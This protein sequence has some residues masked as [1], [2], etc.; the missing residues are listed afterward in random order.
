MAG[1][2]LCTTGGTSKEIQALKN[3]LRKIVRER[4]F[5]NILGQT[6]L[7]ISLNEA[8]FFIPKEVL[9]SL[10]DVYIVRV[11]IDLQSVKIFPVQMKKILSEKRLCL[12]VSVKNTG[13]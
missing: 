13:P 7:N 2:G 12:I 4:D 6:S 9:P 11:T 5:I 8:G 10:K 3:C 1:E